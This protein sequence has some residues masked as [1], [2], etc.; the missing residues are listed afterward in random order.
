MFMIPKGKKKKKK[1]K[2]EKT[3][4]CILAGVFYAKDQCVCVCVRACIAFPEVKE[5]A[6][7][8][9]FLPPNLPVPN[10]IFV[11]LTPTPPHPS[12]DDVSKNLPSPLPYMGLK[13]VHSCDSTFL[14]HYT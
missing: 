5:E 12:N 11:P 1:K 14:S 3:P 9:F 7:E 6:L 13:K 2:K 4:V 10:S 8:L